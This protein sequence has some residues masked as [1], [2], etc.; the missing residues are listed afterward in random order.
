MLSITAF[1]AA[2]S[3]DL[4][5]DDFSSVQMPSQWPVVRNTLGTTTITETGLLGVIG[6]NRR[7][8]ITADF[9][10]LPGLDNITVTAAPTPAG[11]FDYASTSGADGSV[12]LI[13]NGGMAPAF[14]VDLSSESSF[15]I[16]FIYFDLANVDPLDISITITDSLG[17]SR[18]GLASLVGNGAQTLSLPMVGFAENMAGTTDLTDIR[19]INIFFDGALATDFRIDY[20]KTTTVPA[21]GALAVLGMGILGVR[22]RRRR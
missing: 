6:G 5:I 22:R 18:T 14:V 21:P 3:A 10:A 4:I 8:S 7:S 12:R 13:Y 20:I 16:E 11:I 9:L 17:E 1:S 2:A 19:S 15:E